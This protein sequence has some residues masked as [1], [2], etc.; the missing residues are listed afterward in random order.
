MAMLLDKASLLKPEN[1]LKEEKPIVA[2]KKEKKPKAEAPA[3]MQNFSKP[4]V[5]STATPEFSLRYLEPDNCRPWIFA[6]RPTE[7]MGDLEA[8]AKS[9]KEH[10]QQEPVLARLASD[11]KYEII[12]GNRRWRACK[13]IQSRL[14][15]IVKP[16]TDQEAAVFQNEENENRKDLSDL[17]RAR[18][19]KLQVE[20]GVFPSEAA[21]SKALGIST[22]SLNDIMAFNRVP[23]ELSDLIPNFRELSRKTVVKLAVLAKNKKHLPALK[24]LANKIGNKKITAANLEA[25]LMKSEVGKT[26]PPTSVLAGLNKEGKKL[27]TI[28]KKASGSVTVQLTRAAAENVDIEKLRKTLLD[29]LQ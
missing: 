19:Y 24:K 22:Q 17:A 9:I 1:S 29:M 26:V 5:E 4:K 20:S 10:G 21:L 15:A 3:F 25:E 28:N 23:E 14:L 2:E 18:S 27:F 11:G 16:V 13:K 8:L 7:E 12:F 6:D